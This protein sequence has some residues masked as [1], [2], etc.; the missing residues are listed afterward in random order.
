[1]A[2]I[3]VFVITTDQMIICNVVGVV[4]RSFSPES[5]VHHSTF[6]LFCFFLV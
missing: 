4:H 5:G 2:V 6:Q 3:S 1:M